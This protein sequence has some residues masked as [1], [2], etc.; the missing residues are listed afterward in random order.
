MPT[1]DCDQVGGGHRRLQGTPEEA[2]HGRV[3]Q[4]R[5]VRRLTSKKILNKYF[6]ETALWATLQMKINEQ[7]KRF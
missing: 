6:K 2:G 4:G 5:K 7:G 3:K 1:P